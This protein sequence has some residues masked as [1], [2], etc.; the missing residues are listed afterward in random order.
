MFMMKILLSRF[1]TPWRSQLIREEEKKS[2]LYLMFVK[3][4]SLVLAVW[5]LLI[6]K[7]AKLMGILAALSSL[8][9]Y[10]VSVNVVQVF[11]WDRTVYKV[12]ENN[13]RSLEDHPMYV[14]EGI[15]KESS[16]VSTNSNSP[17][18]F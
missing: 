18:L 14:S 12:P 6:I 9:I 15:H 17:H 4:V 13:T 10:K 5:S 11:S 8:L 2:P 1:P 16:K 3:A 7:D